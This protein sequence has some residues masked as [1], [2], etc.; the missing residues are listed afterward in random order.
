MFIVLLAIG[1]ACLLALILVRDATVRL[2]LA[3][4]II[5]GAAVAFV[6]GVA[7]EEFGQLYLGVFGGI[8]GVAFLVATAIAARRQNGEQR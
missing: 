7:R 4:V 1:I 2:V 8:F 6:A 5:V 3:A